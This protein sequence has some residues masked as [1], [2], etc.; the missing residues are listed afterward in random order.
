MLSLDHFYHIITKNLLEPI[1]AD[2]YYFQ[3]FGSID[4]GNLACLNNA[5]YKTPYDA[6]VV[7]SVL[8]YDQEPL[9]QKNFSQLYEY[10]SQLCSWQDLH[11]RNLRDGISRFYWFESRFYLLANSEHS[12]EK[13]SLLKDIEYYDWYYFFHGFAALHWYNNIKYLPPIDNFTK[14]FITFNNLHT[15][16][17]SYRLSLISR[18]IEKKLDTIGHISL[19]AT[20]QSIYNELFDTNSSVSKESKKIIFKE[21]YKKDK[22]YR[23]DLENIDG[24]LSAN[25][26][27]DTLSLGMW[28]LVTET[29]F[30][31]EKLHLTEKIFKPI[32]ARRPFLLVG[33]FKNLDYLR[34]Y[35]FKTFDR[36]INESY[37]N[38][39]DPDLRMIKI[40]KEIEKLSNLSLYDL[41]KMYKE[42]SGVLEHNFTWFYTGFKDKII[43]E[44][45]DNFQACIIKHNAG[46]DSS[47]AGHLN[48]SIDFSK[49]KKQF[50]L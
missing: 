40:V 29:I 13:N 7:S 48:H 10:P 16:K 43:D 23:I 32:V 5:R 20:D 12:Q 27:L 33:A 11:L 45:V 38:E 2:S 6:P 3:K 21:L 28:H 49:I 24:F 47:F 26:N 17:R 25:D 50:K 35:G 18:L 14:L 1:Y 34:S 30:Y 4:F 46:K 42:M 37:D 19:N 39:N 9:Y 15:G 22:K 36:W 44:L 41:R 8:F 31:D